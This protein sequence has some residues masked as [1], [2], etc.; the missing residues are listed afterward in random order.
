M[1]HGTVKFYNTAKSFG[2]VTPDGGGKDLFVS[3]STL[4]SGVT[5]LKSGERVSFDV[6]P[7]ARG[8]MA[9]ALRQLAEPLR[10]LPARDHGAPASEQRTLAVYFDSTDRSAESVLNRL[11]A[12]GF[13][14]T[15]MDYGTTPLKREQLKAL[16]TLLARKNQSLVKRYAALFY[17][18]RLDDRFL[19]Q[20]EF[21]DAIVEHPSLING[22]IVE[23]ADD[24]NLCD[25]KS[26]L[27]AFLKANFPDSP[28]F[29]EERTKVTKRPANEAAAKPVAKPEVL[30]A[31]EG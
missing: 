18:L 25:P 29:E 4:P 12:A 5:A 24:A 30:K 15:L 19:S 9:V 26:G 11:R 1:P 20:T 27:G 2:F 3:A 7:S 14:P 16:S 17:D 28:A 8:A 6:Q 13:E 22:P 23:T 21:W 31:V 10:Q